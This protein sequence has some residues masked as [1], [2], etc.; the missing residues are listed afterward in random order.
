MRANRPLGD[1]RKVTGDKTSLTTKVPEKVLVPTEVIEVLAV[2]HLCS[3]VVIEVS[4]WQ[5]DC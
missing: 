3:L 5:S 2:S 4:S 1:G